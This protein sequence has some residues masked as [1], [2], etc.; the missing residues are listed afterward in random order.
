LL[1]A[2]T[3]Q[4][5]APERCAA[6]RELSIGYGLAAETAR[7]GNIALRATAESAAQALH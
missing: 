6:G 2:L 4:E 1:L 7:K 5:K 3:I